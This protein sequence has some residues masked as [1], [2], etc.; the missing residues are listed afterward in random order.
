MQTNKIT[1]NA[2]RQLPSAIM[3]SLLRLQQQKKEEEPDQRESIT[4]WFFEAILGTAE[5]PNKVF[6]KDFWM[7]RR[8]LRYRNSHKAYRLLRRLLRAVNYGRK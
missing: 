7:K 3:M 2:L 1:Q 8:Y 4:I 6:S 5:E